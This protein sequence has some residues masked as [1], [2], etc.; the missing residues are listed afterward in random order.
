MRQRIVLCGTVV[1]LALCGCGDSAQ[2]PDGPGRPGPPLPLKE[3][4]LNDIHG[5]H[6][7]ERVWIG[8][9]RTAIVQVVDRER[10]E[11]RYRL[12]I[13]AAQWTEIERLVGAHDFL[14]LKEGP[15]R[16]GVPDEPAHTIRLVTKEGQR[17][18]A[19]K[20]ERDQ[21]PR[22]DPLAGVLFG[23]ARTSEGRELIQEG[24]YDYAWT[25]DGFE[26]LW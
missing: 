7:G 2:D 17:A 24:D 16:T 22:F 25:P 9:D 3:I 21:R 11:K 18:K 10:K 26:K 6:G 1:T 19:F 12:K 15:F 5:L 4:V 23:I 14:N 8:A 13:G 20:W